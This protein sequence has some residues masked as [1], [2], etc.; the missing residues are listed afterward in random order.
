M[1]D[2]CRSHRTKTNRFLMEAVCTLTRERIC[3]LDMI[4][5]ALV[6]KK[7]GSTGKRLPK[8]GTRILAVSRLMPPSTGNLMNN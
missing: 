5:L 8:A 3:L 7:I 4:N 1:Y 6:Q 2:D